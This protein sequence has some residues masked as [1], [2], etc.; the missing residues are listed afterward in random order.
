MEKIQNENNVQDNKVEEEQKTNVKQELTPEE[1]RKREEKLKNVF[2][3][4]D[5]KME[6]NEMEKMNRCNIF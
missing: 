3:K 6:E 1:K 2:E 5:R 4:L